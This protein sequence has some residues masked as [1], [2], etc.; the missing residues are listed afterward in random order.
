MKVPENRS[1]P[2]KVGAVYGGNMHCTED[3]S[4]VLSIKRCPFVHALVPSNFPAICI[5]QSGNGSVKLIWRRHTDWKSCW[6]IVLHVTVEN[7]KCMIALWAHLLPPCSICAYQTQTLPLRWP[8]MWDDFCTGVIITTILNG[9]CIPVDIPIFIQNNN[10]TNIFTTIIHAGRM[11][12]EGLSRFTYYKQRR[13]CKLGGSEASR[14]RKL[15][16]HLFLD[17]QPPYTWR[18]CFP[19]C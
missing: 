13:T 4:D 12:A 10:H 2:K 19:H 11:Q 5:W 1:N 3:L 8:N 15:D 7:S 17:G 9:S 18:L 6:H 14:I 16:T